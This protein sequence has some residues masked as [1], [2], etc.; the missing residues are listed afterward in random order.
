MPRAP[1]TGRKSVEQRAIEQIDGPGAAADIGTPQSVV[2]DEHIDAADVAAAT[3]SRDC[4]LADGGG[5]AQ[6]EIETLRADRRNDMGGFADQRDAVG[7]KAPRIGPGE[8]KLPA[9]GLDLDLAEDGMGGVFDFAGEL[10]SSSA[11]SASASAGSSTQT[12]LERLPGSGTKVNGPLGVWN[13]VE[14]SR[15]GRECFRQTVSATCG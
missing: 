15:C 12:R 8:G 10:A 6:A 3:P 9:A 7:G 4:E 14:V 13:S 11:A 2:G 5:V 1:C